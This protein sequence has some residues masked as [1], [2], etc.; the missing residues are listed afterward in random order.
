MLVIQRGGNKLVAI[1]K[2]GKLVATQDKFTHP[3]DFDKCILD[4]GDGSEVHEQKGDFNTFAGIPESLESVSKPVK[5][6]VVPLDTEVVKV[7]V[8]AS[9]SVTEVSKPKGKAK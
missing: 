3:S 1:Y 7:A 2:D 4:H 8:T 6:T 9:E 5:D